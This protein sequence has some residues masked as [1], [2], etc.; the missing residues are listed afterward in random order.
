MMMPPA[1]SMMTP[2]PP[3]ISRGVAEAAEELDRLR[4]VTRTTAGRDRSIW[5]AKE[6]TPRSAS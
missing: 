1:A 5:A 6:K 3:E 4:V 2:E